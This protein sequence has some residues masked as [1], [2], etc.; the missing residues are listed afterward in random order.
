MDKKTVFVDVE[1]E[2]RP[3]PA[4]MRCPMWTMPHLAY[5]LSTETGNVAEI[6]FIVDGDVL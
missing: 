5:V 3:T 2:T 6:V 4:T 1:G